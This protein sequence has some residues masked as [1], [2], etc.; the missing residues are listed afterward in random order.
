MVNHS[1]NY[2]Q[3]KKHY[4]NDKLPVKNIRWG[5]KKDEGH[6]AE[7]VFDNSGKD[8]I[9]KGTEDDFISLVTQFKDVVINGKKKIVDLTGLPIKGTGKYYENIEIFLKDENKSIEEF[10]KEVKE[11]KR[12]LPQENPLIIAKNIIENKFSDGDVIKFLENYKFMKFLYARNLKPIHTTFESIKEK[13]IVDVD[14][15]EFYNK[16]SDRVFVDCIRKLSPIPAFLDFDKYCLTDTEL[17][18]KNF[19]NEIKK[20]DLTWGALYKKTGGT[21]KGEEGIYRIILDYLEIYEIIREPL[22]DLAILIAKEKSLS[23]KEDSCKEVIKC[24]KD[25]GYSD[26]VKPINLNLRHARVHKSIDFNKQQGKLMIYNSPRKNKKLEAE[27]TFS[28]AIGLK[29]EI[30]ILGYALFFNH[31]MNEQIILFKLIDSLD[32]KFYIIQ[33]KK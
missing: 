2:V 8:I 9:L 10:A 31:I 33:N 13:K 21:L 4:Y 7:I 16:E 24:I 5:F 23:I 11:G 26:L 30:R 19:V 25:S 20:Q 28:E 27:I 17:L 18:I 32:F 14:K 22:R 15:F 29:E 12:N 3:V 6:S 1:E